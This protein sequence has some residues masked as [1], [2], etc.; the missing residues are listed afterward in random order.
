MHVI[1]HID[2]SRVKSPI[3][4]V[5]FLAAI[6]GGTATAEKRSGMAS[7]SQEGH[8]CIVFPAAGAILTGGQKQGDIGVSEQLPSYYSRKEQI[9]FGG[10]PPKA[11]SESFTSLF[12]CTSPIP[13]RWVSTLGQ[14]KHSRWIYSC[15]IYLAISSPSWTPVSLQR[16]IFPIIHLLLGFGSTCPFIWF[17]CISNCC[18]IPSCT[19]IQSEHPSSLFHPFAYMP[20]GTFNVDSPSVLRFHFII[21]LTTPHPSAIHHSIHQSSYSSIWGQSSCSEAFHL[22]AFGASIHPFHPSQTN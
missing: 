11:N 3:I 20:E 8:C 15:W 6:R 13:Y 7:Q 14:V 4:L 2:S 5:L 19:S 10:V 1:I 17:S 16:R 22:S 18:C 21:S 12:D 9:A